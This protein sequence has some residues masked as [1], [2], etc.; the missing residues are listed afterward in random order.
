MKRMYTIWRNRLLSLSAATLLVFA[1]GAALLPS[2]AFAASP[3]D[4]VCEGAGLAAGSCATPQGTPSLDHTIA[5]V[6]NI[7]SWIVGIAAVIMIIVAG[8][9]FVTSQGEAS[10]VASARAT[11]LYAIVGIVLVLMAQFLVLFVFNKTTGRP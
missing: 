4:A 6:V 9:K 11:I 10:N 5:L 3:K 8:F 7:F 2:A 1:T